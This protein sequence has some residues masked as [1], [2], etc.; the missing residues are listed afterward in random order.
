MAGAKGHQAPETPLPGLE[1]QLTAPD[2]DTMG[3]GIRVR[4]LWPCVYGGVE[5][6]TFAFPLAS[7]GRG[8]EEAYILA[9]VV[10]TSPV[11]A[12]R[13]CPGGKPLSGQGW[14]WTLG[15]AAR[16]LVAAGQ[17]DLHIGHQ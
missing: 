12:A 11:K 9:R 10:P 14:S 13:S 17:L 5:E 3:W 7:G 2:G 4:V 1:I 8:G 16:Q 6:E 15:P